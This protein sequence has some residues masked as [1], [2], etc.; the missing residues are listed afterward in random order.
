[1]KKTLKISGMMII[2]IASFL[3]SSINVFAQDETD[4]IPAEQP[5]ERPARPAFESGLIFDDASTTIQPSNTLEFVI[6]HRFGTMNN[7]TEDLFG[8]WAPS[9]IRLGINYSILNNLMVGVG[10]TK[11]NKM[12]DFQAKYNVIQQTRSGSI[13]V[14]VSVYEIIG[15]NAT[16]EEN[17]GV[18]YK[19]S[20]RL[21]YF[22]Q[23]IVSR[24][25]ND[26]FSLQF[27][28]SFT[29][30]NSLDSLIDH[31][32]LSLS[33]AARYKFSP[34][35]SIIFSGTWPLYIQSLSEQNEEYNNFVK[36][37][38]DRVKPNIT[39]GW[40]ISTSTHA[41]HIYLG[42]AQNI[43]P[44]ENIMFNKNDFFDSGLL[45]GL[46]ITRLWSF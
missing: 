44:Q 6:Q 26:N 18:N 21:S 30:Y 29:H 40:E 38:G 9:N 2:L 31:D 17:F 43:L 41:F 24:R 28:P 16:D 4:S 36:D 13:P 14:T 15:L 35:S 3:F 27:A 7:G 20:H 46:N 22:T 19:F 11:F 34:Q 39:V 32:R 10:T 23:L 5:K 12:Q 33:A 25:F 8:I 37:Q 42:S 45:L 1:M